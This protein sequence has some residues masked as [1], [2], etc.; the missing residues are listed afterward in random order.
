MRP[1]ALVL[2]ALCLTACGPNLKGIVEHLSK[3][4]RSWC[5][6]ATGYGVDVKIGGSG[7][8]TGDMTCGG[9]GL[10]LQSKGA[11]IG[12]PMT[13]VPQMSIGQPT[14]APAGKP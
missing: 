10:V 6:S 12:I 4:E 1:L 7:V 13:L 11:Q 5:L 3:S 9:S 8:D 2:A 14:L